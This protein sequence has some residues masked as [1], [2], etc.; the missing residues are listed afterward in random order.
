MHYCQRVQGPLRLL[1]GD[2]GMLVKVLA[3]DAAQVLTRCK[4]RSS[5]VIKKN[6][7]RGGPIVAPHTDST[8]SDHGT[9][10]N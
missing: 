3:D 8:N 10:F 7:N 4:R 2:R 6:S 5:I 1:I 9:T